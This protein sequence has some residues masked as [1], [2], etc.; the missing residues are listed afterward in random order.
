MTYTG[1][2]SDSSYGVLMSSPF[3]YASL[4]RSRSSSRGSWPA[5]ASR[6]SSRALRAL[7][8]RSRG[9]ITS[10][11][12]SMLPVVPSLRRTPLPRT[13][14][15]RPFGVPGGIRTVTGA[16]RC[17][18]TLTS[19]PRVSS[20]KS[21]GTVTVRFAPDRPNSGCGFT[22]T[23][24]YR[25]PDGPPRSPGAPLPASLIRWPSATPAGMRAWMVR[26]LIARPL[27]VHAGQGSST[28]R[29]RPWHSLHT[30]D[31]PKEPRFL[32]DCPVPWQDGHILGT[33][34][35]LAPV[36]WQ[37]G[38]GP[39]P[40]SRSATVVPSIASLKVSDVSVSTSAPRRARLWVV[41]RPRL[42]TPPKMSPRPPPSP[43]PLKMSPRSKPPNPPW[44]GRCPVGTR[45]PPPN[46]ER[47]SSYSLRRFSSDSTE[48]ASEISLNRSSAEASPL[49]ASGWYLRA[50]LRYAALI[51]AGLAV[52]ATPRAL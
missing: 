1:R 23:R 49:F 35:A 51:S 25:S 4:A 29:P 11:V 12:T 15:V 19:A 22:C 46:S 27:P 40:V 6:R 18:G 30:S 36:P 31:I 10:T 5:V 28:T 33:V 20:A 14:N 8:V 42:N 50:S 17:D 7:L 52:L 39:S 41:V 34:P 32:L 2:S 44:P 48:Y 16:P 21:T 37:V 26:E 45:K 9:T 24:T 13:M 38:Q 3:L 47:A 43:V